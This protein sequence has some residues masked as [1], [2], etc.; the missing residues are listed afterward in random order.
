MVNHSLKKGFY[1]YTLTTT[2]N[3]NSFSLLKLNQIGTE[4]QLLSKSSQNPTV[5]SKS[6]GQNVELVFPC[7]KE[8]NPH[9]HSPEGSVHRLG[10][11]HIDLSY[12][13]KNN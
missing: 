6:V 3:E 5:Q 12:K 7:N 8:D 1:R 11:W 10:I 13:I 2:Q 9:R 4:T